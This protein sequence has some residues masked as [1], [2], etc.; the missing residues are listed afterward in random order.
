MKDLFIHYEELPKVVQDLIINEGEVDGYEGCADLLSKTE[1]LGYTFEY[2]L[3]AEPY[4]L[5]KM[6]L[7]LSD[8][9]DVVEDVDGEKWSQLCV[10]HRLQMEKEG[11]GH[12]IHSMGDGV[13]G[14]KGCDVESEHYIDFQK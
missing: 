2:G 9:D 3:D 6:N 7:D 11:T 5:R 13:C 8:F 12:Y 1:A 4:N 14:V 10:V